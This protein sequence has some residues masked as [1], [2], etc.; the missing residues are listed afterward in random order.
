MVNTQEYA[1]YK[2]TTSSGIIM[3]SKTRRQDHVWK[4][5]GNFKKKKS[6]Y[7]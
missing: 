3:R 4:T 7:N 1:C 5:T 2:F 6:K